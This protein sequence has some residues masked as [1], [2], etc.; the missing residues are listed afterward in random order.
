MS[1]YYY[2]SISMHVISQGFKYI[3]IYCQIKVH[4]Y[5]YSFINMMQVIVEIQKLITY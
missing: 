2:L 1:F 4:L 5:S 3:L